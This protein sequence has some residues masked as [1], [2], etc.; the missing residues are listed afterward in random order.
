M[1]HIRSAAVLILHLHCLVLCDKQIVWGCPS[2]L[3]TANNLNFSVFQKHDKL[4]YLWNYL[5]S[6][7]L[8]ISY[9]LNFDQDVGFVHLFTTLNS[10]AWGLSAWIQRRE[11]ISFCILR[12]NCVR[13]DA[14]YHI[15]TYIF[16]PL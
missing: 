4:L 6:N 13:L 3:C 15:P 12:L 1:I 5:A 7:A 10:K 9:F 16:S 8:P 11:K 2:L 14:T